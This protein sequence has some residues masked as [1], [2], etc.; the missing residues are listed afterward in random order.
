MKLLWFRKLGDSTWTYNTSKRKP[1]VW[2]MCLRNNSS[3]STCLQETPSCNSSEE[4]LIFN[5]STFS[6]I[7]DFSNGCS[8]EE[9]LGPPSP[10]AEAHFIHPNLI[11]STP[12]VGY[13]LC[14]A[15]HLFPFHNLLPF[16][17]AFIFPNVSH[18][19]L[20][21]PCV[22]SHQIIS[23]FPPPRAAWTAARISNSSNEALHTHPHTHRRKAVCP[24][25]TQTLHQ[26]EAAGRFESFLLFALLSCHSSFVPGA[27]GGLRVWKKPSFL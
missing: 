15:A 4:N 21:F 7:A 6:T 9:T 25:S 20:F 2:R 12:G 11:V 10:A 3:F 17:A 19:L 5:C 24:S 26:T 22:T 16:I 1:F 27:Q 13:L 18:P 8:E 14:P 23:M